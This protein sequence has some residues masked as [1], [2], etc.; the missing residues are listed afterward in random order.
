MSWRDERNVHLIEEFG[1]FEQIR[2]RCIRKCCRRRRRRRRCQRLLRRTSLK[3]YPKFISNIFQKL[4]KNT[5]GKPLNVNVVNKSMR[6]LF[7]CQVNYALSKL[8][9]EGSNFRKDCGNETL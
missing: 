5:E 4:L 9:I 2:I 3:R 8:S 6:G 7:D 1:N